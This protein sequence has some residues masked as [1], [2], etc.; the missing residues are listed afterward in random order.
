M[1]LRAWPLLAF[2]TG[3]ATASALAADLP[4]TIG[5]AERGTLKVVSNVLLTATGGEMKGVWLDRARPC[6]ERRRLT[7]RLEIDLVKPNGAT[8]R[9][10]YVK[11]G[12]VANCAEGGPNFG[13]DLRPRALGMGCAD[14]SWAPGRYAIT[15]RAV[16]GRTRLQASASLYRQVT[17][18]C[19][20]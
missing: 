20:A 18:P 11:F 16:E 8:Q 5:V 4:S 13:F 6:R 14:G 12:P 3:A 9:A 2:L 10:R 19:P 1:P 15:T 17:R 7:V